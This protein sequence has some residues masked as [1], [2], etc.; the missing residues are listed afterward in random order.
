MHC[1][2]CHMK[3][4]NSICS[5]RKPAK[6]EFYQLIVAVNFN[7]VIS[8]RRLIENWL[9][10]N[11]PNLSF[12]LFDSIPHINIVKMADLQVC[13]LI[14]FHNVRLFLASYVTVWP[15]RYKR[16]SW[17]SLNSNHDTRETIQ[18]Y[19]MILD[20][21]AI[22]RFVIPPPKLLLLLLFVKLV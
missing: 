13:S 21:V 6:P 11:I 9:I 20:Y 1:L 4:I 10:V 5:F 2:V 8:Y 15:V 16:R 7:W 3:D 18:I 14:Y 22:P 19:I 17:K 12:I